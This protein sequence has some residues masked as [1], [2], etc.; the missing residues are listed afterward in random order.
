[1]DTP[2]SSIEVA[3]EFTSRYLRDCLYAGKSWHVFSCISH[4]PELEDL[5]EYLSRDWK[6]RSVIFKPERALPD[7]YEILCESRYGVES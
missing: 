1:M 5:V 4:P 7:R 3:K 2:I 6:I